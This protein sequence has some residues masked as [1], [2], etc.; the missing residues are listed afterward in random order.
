MRLQVRRIDDDRGGGRLL[1]FVNPQWQ[2]RG[3]VVSDFGCVAVAFLLRVI[4]KL[5]S[6]T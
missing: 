1:L 6:Q 3:Q 5:S 4:S 2:T